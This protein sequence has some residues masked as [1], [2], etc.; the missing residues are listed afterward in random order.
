M[1][2]ALII[3]FEHAHRPASAG[4]LQHLS[5]QL[6]AGSGRGMKRGHEPT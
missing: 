6:T 3:V 4:D 5:L 2:R 1:R